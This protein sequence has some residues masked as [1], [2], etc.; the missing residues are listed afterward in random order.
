MLLRHVPHSAL[1]LVL[2]LAAGLA[3][4]ATAAAAAGAPANA[5][6]LKGYTIQHPRDTVDICRQFSG[7]SHDVPQQVLAR[8][9]GMPLTLLSHKHISLNWFLQL[10]QKTAPDTP[11]I[12]SPLLFDTT[13][14]PTAGS[15]LPQLIHITVPDKLHL[16]PHQV[17]AIASWAR[18]N[19]TWNVLLY[20]DSDIDAFMV[21]YYPDLLPTYTALSSQ[22][23]RTDL[24]RYLVLCTFGGVYADSDVISGRP[25]A[26]WALE[27]AGLLVGVENVFSTLAAAKERTYTQQVQ[28][29][30]WIIAAKR[31]HP[32]VC[33]MGEYVRQHLTKEAAGEF[34]DPDRDHAILERTGPG[35]WSS[36]VH[37]YLSQHGVDATEVV[38][39]AL[40]G[41]VRILP[42][43]VFGCGANMYSPDI[44]PSAYVY[45]M[46]KGT[47]RVRPFYPSLA[48]LLME[49]VDSL[50]LKLLAASGALTTGQVTSRRPVVLDT[51]V[52]SPAQAAAAAADEGRGAP[53]AA[54]VHSSSRA[55]GEALPPGSSSSSSSSA[56]SGV[57]LHLGRPHHSGKAAAA[58]VHRLAMEK[59]RTGQFPLRLHLVLMVL[60]AVVL[61]GLGVVVAATLAGAACLSW[62][63]MPNPAKQRALLMVEEV[64]VASLKR[65]MAAWACIR[66]TGE[67]ATCT[68]SSSRSSRGRFGTTAH[69]RSSSGSSEEGVGICQFISS[70]STA[71]VLLPVQGYWSEPSSPRGSAGDALHAQWRRFVALLPAPNVLSSHGH[72]DLQYIKST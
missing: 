26:S 24:W 28:M 9:L 22:V 52:V 4:T 8:E 58:M 15:P 57:T 69:R 2:V 66:C 65:A 45:H 68:R 35:I 12:L 51:P 25:V 17:L 21:T 46:F 40:V 3:A 54:P 41:D 47:W 39:G 38:G 61:L 23:E 42:Q 1:T 31:G 7:L 50:L 29:V 72:S 10:M 71:E 49:Q 34:F 64:Q 18:H 16:Q 70:S 32:V 27:G 56:S 43:P 62:R 55:G 53:G 67:A 48:W 30:Q 14:T 59:L 19:P 44:N 20:D 6:V 11:I 5:P 63:Y 13:V 33:R 37:D 36:S 60:R